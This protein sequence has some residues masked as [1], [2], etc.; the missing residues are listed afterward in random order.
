LNK[1][2]LH[3]EFIIQPAYYDLIYVHYISATALISRR[4]QFAF[5]CH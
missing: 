4:V 2:Y 5:I 3:T 1:L